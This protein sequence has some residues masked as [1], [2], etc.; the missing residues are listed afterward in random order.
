MLFL[1]SPSIFIINNLYVDVAMSSVAERQKVDD[2][3][4]DRDQIT[5]VKVLGSGNF[6]QVSKAVYKPLNSEVAVKSLKG[7]LHFSYHFYISLG[8]TKIKWKSGKALS[9][10]TNLFISF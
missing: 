9:Y 1:L 5:T 8:R 6:S 7:T 4:L 10:F 2:F 3:R